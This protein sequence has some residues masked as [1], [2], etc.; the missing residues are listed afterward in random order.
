MEKIFKI[1]VATDR[2]AILCVNG[3]G[4][5]CPY[6]SSKKYVRIEIDGIKH[7]LMIKS[8]NV[9]DGFNMMNITDDMVVCESPGLNEIDSDNL[10][11]IKGMVLVN[12]LGH[13]IVESEAEYV[14]LYCEIKRI[15]SSMGDSKTLLKSLENDGI[16]TYCGGYYPSDY[17]RGPMMSTIEYTIVKP[18]NDK[19][20]ARSICL[21]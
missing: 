13:Y 7:F 8:T 19:K 17:N 4:S 15:I 12:R 6:I 9:A 20:S 18:K 3:D 14:L 2:P 10:F 5:L 1:R 21:C 11:G 16:D